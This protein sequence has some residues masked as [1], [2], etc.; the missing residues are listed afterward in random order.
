MTVDKNQSEPSK[1]NLDAEVYNLPLRTCPFP[2]RAIPAAFLGVPLPT[3]A[4]HRR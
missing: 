3:T 2:R 4:D 1:Y